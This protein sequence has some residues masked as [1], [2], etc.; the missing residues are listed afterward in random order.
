VK[1]QALTPVVRGIVVPAGGPFDVLSPLTAEQSEEVSPGLVS[2]KYNVN[3]PKPNGR[4]A[5]I[6]GFI[7][8]TEADEKDGTASGIVV[9]PAE[10]Q[11]V[12]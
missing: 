10:V 11:S 3:P 6:S 7:K 12:D 9:S 5:A 8:G 2:R 4:G 1:K